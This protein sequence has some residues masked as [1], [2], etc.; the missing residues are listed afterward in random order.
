MSAIFLSII[1]SLFG[2]DGIK[3]LSRLLAVPLES[4]QSI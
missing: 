2:N 1:I 4:D 3:K